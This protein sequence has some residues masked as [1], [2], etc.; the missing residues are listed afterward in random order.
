MKFAD[1][2]KVYFKIGADGE[3][4]I[5]PPDPMGLDRGVLGHAAIGWVDIET[6]TIWFTSPL[7][8][9]VKRG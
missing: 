8:E 9:G 1:H 7:P 3:I 6:N 4:Y 5:V 2:E